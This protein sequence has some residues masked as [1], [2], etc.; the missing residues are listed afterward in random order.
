MIDS[1]NTTLSLFQIN[2][3]IVAARRENFRQTADEL[4]MTQAAVSRNIASME[5]ALGIVLFVRHKKQVRLTEAGRYLAKQFEQHLDRIDIS[6]AKAF[7]IQKCNYQILRI[8]DYD[9][10][11][12]DEYL[13]PICDSFQEK[14]P[15]LEIIISR[16]HPLDVIKKLAD[17]EFDLIFTTNIAAELL[18]SLHLR[19]ETILDLVPKIVISSRHSKYAK[20]DLSYRDLL[21]NTILILDGGEYSEYNNRV[22]QL[23][24]EYKFN[25][26]KIKLVK[27]PYSMST[28]LLRNDC[29]A[30]MDDLY[31]PGS[32]SGMRYINLPDCPVAFG[33]AIAYSPGNDNP[34]IRSFISH[35]KKLFSNRRLST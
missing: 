12:A 10:T 16:L 24:Q 27:D 20:K 4:H 25:K 2:V 6:V 28:E 33:L 35:S 30:L 13:L 14:H 21:D 31:A 9:T 17:G 1:R 8:G 11:P 18:K 26:S 29:I 32:R 19:Y 34:Y 3:F 15:D 5:N 7:D 22:Y 23:L